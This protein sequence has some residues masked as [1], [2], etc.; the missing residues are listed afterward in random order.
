MTGD[1]L[2]EKE[3]LG[4]HFSDIQVANEVRMLMRS[5]F[6]HEGVCCMARDRIMFLSQQL[7][8]AIRKIHVAENLMCETELAKFKKVADSLEINGDGR[9]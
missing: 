9:E 6:N 2:T 3:L 1:I 8:L 4:A 7:D 5:T